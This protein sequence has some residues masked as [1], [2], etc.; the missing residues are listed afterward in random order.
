MVKK[1]Q[2]YPNRCHPANTSLLK[3]RE[4]YGD[5]ATRHDTATTYEDKPQD[6]RIMSIIYR[7]D[8]KESRSING[9]M[10]LPASVKL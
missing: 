7:H 2:K 4:L 6:D 3:E 5:P 9:T 1:I 10:T 8:T